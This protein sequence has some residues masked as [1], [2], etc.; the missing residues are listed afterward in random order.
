M[1]AESFHMDTAKLR[2][3]GFVPDMDAYQAVER[4]LA[5]LP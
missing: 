3:L 1:Q 2:G 4:T 5:A